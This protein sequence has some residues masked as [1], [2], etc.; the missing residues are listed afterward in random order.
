MRFIRL[1]IK[2]GYFEKIFDFENLT[3]IKSKENSV[4]KTSLLR[5]LL[6]SLGFQI[7]STMG[8]NFENYTFENFVETPTGRKIVVRREK[9]YIELI[10]EA[11]T[12]IFTLPIE[13][14]NV[15]ERV[16]E[17][18][19]RL[20][21]E[22]LLGAFYF[23]QEKGWTL[24]NRGKVIGKIP[25]N[26]EKLISGLSNRSVEELDRELALIEDNLKKYIIMRNTAQYQKELLKQ[27]GPKSRTLEPGYNESREIE[28]KLER[29]ELDLEL[30]KLE[31]VIKK[32]RS[33]IKYVSSFDIR[34]ISPDGSII[35]VDEK[36]VVG[37]NDQMNYLI[38]KRKLLSREVVNLDKA[39]DEVSRKT[40]Q[41]TLFPKGPSISDRFNFE[42]LG[43]DLNQER[44]FREIS[45]L[46]SQRA[47]IRERRT[48]M[49]K[50]NNPIIGFLYN[51]VAKYTRELEVNHCISPRSDY[52]FTD[53]LKGLSGVIL[54]KIVFSFKLAY[55]L[56]IQEY[57]NVKL[58]L[59]VDSPRSKEIT[60]D[61]IK[62]MMAILPR[63]FVDHQVIVASLYDF[64]LDYSK[65]IIVEDQLLGF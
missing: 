48:A 61:E 12:D 62:R 42:V 9:D 26:I 11:N 13:L 19:N 20:V 63:D 4:G 56:A 53:N 49:I 1:V 64:G 29:Q 5:M 41:D 44:I 65:E 7:P 18:S 30:K 16:F 34:V 45:T 31:A 60:E 40:D 51:I 50:L 39:I 14:H 28:L 38:E 8:F 6:Y 17:I 36:T 27:F 33:F 25:F 10:E 37:F 22:N 3:L 35:P 47:I 24:L 23:D 59:I 54:H 15:L 2:R 57:C 58:P 52:I 55:I 32:N 46:E 21:L 43:L